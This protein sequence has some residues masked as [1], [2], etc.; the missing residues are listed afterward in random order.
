[1]NDNK[2]SSSTEQVFQN[3]RKLMQVAW[4]T[5][6]VIVVSLSAHA[7]TTN[8]TITL[9]PEPCEAFVQSIVT[10]PQSPSADAEALLDNSAVYIDDPNLDSFFLGGTVTTGPDADQEDTTNFSHVR[11][12]LVSAQTNECDALFDVEISFDFEW[13]MGLD[14][15]DGGGVAVLAG[16]TFLDA[17][18]FTGLAPQ[19]ITL[20]L[21]G[22]TAADIAQLEI[23][24]A[25]DTAQGRQ[26][27]IS[28]FNLV[29]T[30][31]P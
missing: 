26:T 17:V 6:T 27:V 5:P 15:P 30:E 4:V 9:P 23:L 28:N 10:S 7:Q 16:S 21:P 18:D 20:A 2:N 29:I 31:V 11:A 3:R 1:M 14:D 25:V 22:L 8:E 12:L 13:T 24:I 19:T